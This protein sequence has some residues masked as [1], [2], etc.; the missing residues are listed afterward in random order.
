MFLRRKRKM[1]KT[2]LLF[3]LTAATLATLGLASCGG[4][5]TNNSSA[6]NPST[7]PGS[8]PTATT[9]GSTVAPNPTSAPTGEI[10][11]GLD[12][13]Y[14]ITVWVSEIVGFDE[15]TKS[16]IKA[17]DDKYSNVT[18]NATV[19]GVSESESATQMIADVE[20]GADIFAFAQDQ[21]ARLV[22]AGAV[23][24]LG[25][26][27][28]ETVTANNDAIS[29]K[30]ASVSGDLYCYPLT[31]DNGYFMYY[32]KSVVQESSLDS[33]EAIIADCEAA[34]R[35]FSYELEGSAWYNAG[36]FFGTGCHSNWTTNADGSDFASVDDNFNSEAGLIALKG[37]QK[38]VTSSAYVN[39]SNVSDFNAA[40]PSAVVISGTWGAKDAKAALG[41]NFGA[42]DLPS[43]TVDGNS[44]HIGSFSGNKLLGVKPQ[45]DPKRA[46]LLREL[47]LY[48]TGE[49]CQTQRFENHG[50]GPSN[51][52]A[53]QLDAVKADV[54][55]AALQLQSPYATPQG[56]I[57]GSWWDIAKVYATAAKEATS[58]ADLQTALD[59][60]K[61][62]ID[63]LFQMS[64]EEKRA[65]TVI[66]AIKGTTW[67]TDFAMEEV[68]EG[69]WISVDKFDLDAGAEFKCRQGKSWDVSIGDGAGNNFK[70][71]TAG[72]YY[73]KLTFVGEV[74][75]IT[76]ETS[77]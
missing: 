58:D 7:N 72:S 6:S 14:D 1:K 60:Y 59:N 45:L 25:K 75:T 40:I 54:A 39:S 12:G 22:T 70:V 43:F 41:E 5:G 37:I 4:N 21:L 42:T 24:K 18:I 17:F 74:G 69:V 10:L 55:L 50:W 34:G 26:K 19:E 56:Q 15:L 27:A 44:Y 16:Q 66:G 52:N 13:T 2:K 68:S 3:G 38:V 62:A 63:E 64:E 49:E 8:K 31:S 76:L 67:D 51:V 48:L 77:K 33:L 35:G 32:D 53:Q 36:F 30:A 47:A 23:G 28:S 65:W 57:H 46:A 73:I 9:P 29:V 11:E 71:E 20:S 61:T